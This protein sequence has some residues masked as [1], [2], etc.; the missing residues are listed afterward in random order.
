VVEQMDW[1]EISEQITERLRPFL[2]SDRK[3]KIEKILSHRIFDKQILLENI[4]DR[5]N[6]A[7]VLRT[8]EAMGVSHI[9]ILETQ[10]EF[11][12]SS[13]VT[14]GADH[15]LEIES[16][17]QTDTCFSELKK[18]GFKLAVTRLGAPRKLEEIDFKD[19]IVFVFGNEKEGVSSRAIEMADIEFEIPMYGFTQS[20]NISVAA[21]LC[22]KEIRRTSQPQPED[23]PLRDRLRAIYY[24]RSYEHSKKMIP[25]DWLDRFS[26]L[27][28]RDLK[29]EPGFDSLW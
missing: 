23:S 4:Y 10:P 26:F 16:W 21:A 29:T 18:R 17:G 8:A 12:I 25:K 2:T 14:Q 27:D 5:G 24:L 1:V 3:E 13:R 15:W 22:L 7:A 9:H 11:K 28:Q 6:V 20:F 19:P